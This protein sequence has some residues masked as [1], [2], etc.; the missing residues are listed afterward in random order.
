VYS[1]QILWDHAYKNVLGRYYGARGK[2]IYETIRNCRAYVSVPSPDSMKSR[3]I[4][5]DIP[6]GYVPVTSL[7][8]VAGVPTPNFDAMISMANAINQVDYRSEGR[9]LQKL[10]LDRMDVKQILQYANDGS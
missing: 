10:G 7:A 9:T 8:K 6:Y 2:D 4:T 3:Y 5:E 1:S